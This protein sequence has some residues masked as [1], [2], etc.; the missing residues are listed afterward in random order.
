MNTGEKKSQGPGVGLSWLVVAG[1]WAMPMGL[2]AQ[3][4]TPP[5]AAAQAPETVMMRM[6]RT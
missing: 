6:R 4:P 1:L 5:P 2:M 3:E